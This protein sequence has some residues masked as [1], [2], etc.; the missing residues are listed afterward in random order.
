MKSPPFSYK[1]QNEMTPVILLGSYHTGNSS[2]DVNADHSDYYVVMETTFYWASGR[3][4]DVNGN[5]AIFG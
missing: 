1:L 5:V 4:S 3:A 2:S